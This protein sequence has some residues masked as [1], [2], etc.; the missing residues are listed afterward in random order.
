[1]RGTGHQVSHYQSWKER[2]AKEMPKSKRLR[3]G[4]RKA[5]EETLN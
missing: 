3:G 1:M 5:K 2:K 4:G